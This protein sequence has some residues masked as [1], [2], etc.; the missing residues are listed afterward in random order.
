[1]SVVSPDGVWEVPIP[2]T[3]QKL[4][5]ANGVEMSVI[6]EENVPLSLNGQRVDMVALVSNEVA[7]VVL[8]GSATDAAVFSYP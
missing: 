1:V 8:A 6:G 7:E 2:K 5:A 3:N 4:Y